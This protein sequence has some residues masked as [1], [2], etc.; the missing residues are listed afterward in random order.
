MLPEPTLA[1][2][3][4][5]RGDG[6]EVPETAAQAVAEA[7]VVITM[8]SDGATV[9]DLF[10]TQDLA[11]QMKDGAILIDMSS[12][13]REA[14]QHAEL[15]RERGLRHLDAPVSGGTKGAEAAS[16]AIM[17]G[18]D[19]AVIKMPFRFCLPWADPGGSG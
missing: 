9:H 8:L 4:A 19:E 3:E 7:D 15:M 18:G 17:A 2:A 5:L 12:I 16:L 1:K 11:A 14:R 13:T 10:F 6:A